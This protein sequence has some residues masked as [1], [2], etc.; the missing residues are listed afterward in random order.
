MDSSNLDYIND[1]KDKNV[2]VIIGLLSVSVL[3]FLIWLIYFKPGASPQGGTWIN[4]LPVVNAFLNTLTSIFLVTGYALIKANNIDWHK[5][6]MYSA[7]IT[8]AL[9]LV[10]YIAYHH[11]HGDTK[12]LALGFIRP[13]YFGILISHILLSAIQVP[14][15]LSTLY[16]ALT[17]KFVKHKKVARITF[18]IWL[19]V[20]V[21]GVLIFVILK[22]FNA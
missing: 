7:T 13:V 20:S 19:Y 6:F 17:K 4:L 9:F 5:R 22:W 1:T 14:L 15:I 2:F 3:A 8:S 12:F 10:S 21:T 16:L 18:P 11:F